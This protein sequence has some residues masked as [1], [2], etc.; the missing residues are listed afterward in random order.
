MTCGCVHAGVGYPAASVAV[1]KP[2]SEQVHLNVPVAVV[3]SV[4]HQLYL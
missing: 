2:V 1:D 3:M 4:S